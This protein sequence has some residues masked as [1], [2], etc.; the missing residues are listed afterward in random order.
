MLTEASDIWSNSYFETANC[1]KC[2]I[3]GGCRIESGMLSTALRV[4]HF[5]PVLKVLTPD[6]SGVGELQAQ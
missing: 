1:S 4:I 2:N 3:N 6:V 5:L